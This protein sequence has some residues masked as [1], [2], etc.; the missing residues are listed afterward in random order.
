MATKDRTLVAM[1][2]CIKDLPTYPYQSSTVFPL[3]IRD[4]ETPS[5]HF[6]GISH[7]SVDELQH[8]CNWSFSA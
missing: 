2:L 3:A 6:M 5:A 8:S 1:I 7:R 4:F